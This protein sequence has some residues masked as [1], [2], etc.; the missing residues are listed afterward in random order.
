MKK[1]VIK[2]AVKDIGELRRRMKEIS[3]E[4]LE[5]VFQHDR[6]YRP[7]NYQPSQNFPRL[8]MRTE[9]RG[10]E[11]PARYFLTLKRHILDSGVDMVNQIEVSNYLETTSLIR[12]LGF[13]EPV[14]VSRRRQML[15]ISEQTTLYLD[16]LDEL[17]G[18]YFKIETAVGEEKVG[19]VFRE[20][21]ETL[22]VFGLA[23]EDIVS[24]PYFELV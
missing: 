17:P 19:N 14:E 13:A 15:M 8:I 6:V 1:A 24:V 11:K 9:V 23:E 5:P 18:Y 7:R 10:M 12:P 4:F 2:C 20:L 22:G 16:Q 3:L 21:R